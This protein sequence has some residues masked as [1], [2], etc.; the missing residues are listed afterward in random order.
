MDLQHPIKV[1]ARRTGLSQHVIRV[2]EKRY[3]AVE[4]SRTDTNRRLY[5][6]NEIERLQLLQQLTQAGHSISRIARLPLDQLQALVH[7][8]QPAT[9]PE[10]INTGTDAAPAPTSPDKSTETFVDEAM[11]AIR[12]L[13]DRTLDDVLHR[14]SVKLGCQG[15]LQKMIVPLTQRIGTAWEEGSI[16]V[17]HEHFAS[18]TLCT[19]LH[20]TAKPFALPD[21]A[22]I[23]AVATPAG[24]IHELGAVLVAAAATN[25]GWRVK[26]L[27]TN[28]PAHEITGAATQSQAR[29]VALSVVYPDD[30]PHL[31]QE[32]I[33][34]RKTLPSDIAILIGG[35]AAGS[36]AD[37]ISS[38]GASLLPDL[39]QFNRKLDE[40]RTSA[41]KRRLRS[42]E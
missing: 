11:A 3:N 34:L 5:S 22:P 42:A 17:A 30:D 15:L 9:T 38:I 25:K 24:Q 7:Q 32:L 36:Y 19:F 37:T 35:R 13:N 40:L 27:G 2:W 26:Y 1:V 28:L 4:P 29:A 16:K 18:A 6:D 20:N 23:L 10:L 31:I 8:A 14:A 21:S 12:D 39:P 41:P 33:C